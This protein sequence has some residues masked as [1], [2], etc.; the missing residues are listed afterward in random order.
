MTRASIVVLDFQYC[1]WNGSTY[2][3]FY[4]KNTSFFKYSITM[5]MFLTKRDS[6][7]LIL[8]YLQEHT[9]KKVLSI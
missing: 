2:N 6:I 3:L 9:E 7:A 8:S 5:N 1:N 4:N